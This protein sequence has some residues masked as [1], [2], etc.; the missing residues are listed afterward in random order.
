[1]F[2]FVQV[3]MIIIMNASYCIEHIHGRKD[4]FLGEN[5]DMHELN[6]FLMYL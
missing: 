6:S 5:Y 3:V 2:V 1:M 4:S